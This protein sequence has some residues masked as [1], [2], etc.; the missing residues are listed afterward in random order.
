MK[1]KEKSGRWL[2]C[3]YPSDQPLAY[4]CP[5]R[6]DARPD[7]L[8]AVWMCAGRG[9]RH[10]WR[11]LVSLTLIAG[12]GGGAAIAAAAGA[13]RA[14]SAYPRFRVATNAFDMVIGVSGDVP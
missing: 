10:R 14:E 1:R 4:P 9:V 3:M 7:G 11:A 2:S 5:R 8:K 6:S 12:L 13:R